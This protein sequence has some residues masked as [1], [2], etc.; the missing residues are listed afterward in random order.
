MA[1]TQTSLVVVDY[2]M[3]VRKSVSVNRN[4]EHCTTFQADLLSIVN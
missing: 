3:Y 1:I 2:F 4:P